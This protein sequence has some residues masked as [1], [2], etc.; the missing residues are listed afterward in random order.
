MVVRL[1]LMYSFFVRQVARWHSRRQQNQKQSARG[2]GCVDIAAGVSQ[3]KPSGCGALLLPDHTK[4]VGA[5]NWSRAHRDPL[6]AKPHSGFIAGRP[7]SAVLRRPAFAW[8]SRVHVHS[9]LEAWTW[10]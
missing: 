10:S 5:R 7:S 8:L 3:D 9:G 2:H 6:C 1:E 4:D